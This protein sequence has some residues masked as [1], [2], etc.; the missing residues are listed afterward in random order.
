MRNAAVML[1]R[2]QSIHGMRTGML[3]ISYSRRLLA[4]VIW[5]E[6]CAETVNFKPCRQNGN[7]ENSQSSWIKPSADGAGHDP[8]EIIRKLHGWLAQRSGHFYHSAQAALTDKRLSSSH[9]HL[10][11]QPDRHHHPCLPVCRSIDSTRFDVVQVLSQA[12]AP[13]GAV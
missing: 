13:S 4:I 7:K 3:F 6:P 12:R 1:Q 10:D 2:P 9:H 11:H 5:G 8:W